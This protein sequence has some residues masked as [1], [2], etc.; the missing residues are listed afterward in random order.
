MSMRPAGLRSNSPARRPPR[1]GP[2]CGLV[3]VS[4]ATLACGAGDRGGRDA[5]GGTGGARE[6]GHGAGGDGAPGGASGQAGEPG[7]AGDSGQAGEAGQA[8][9]P[10]QGGE[11]AAGGSPGAGGA[12]T[13][14][15]LSRP[16]DS[17]SWGAPYRISVPAGLTLRPGGTPL[18]TEPRLPRA[19]PARAELSRTMALLRASTAARPSSLKVLFYG[20]SIT[21]QEWYEQVIRWFEAT[22]PTVRFQFAMLASGGQPAAKMRRASEHDVIPL[23][24]DLIIYQ[25]YGDYLDLDAIVR[26][27]R[28]RTTAEIVLQTWHLG[29][30]TGD[31][32]TSIERMSYL[33]MPNVCERYGCYLLDVRTA[34]KDHVRQNNLANAA[35]TSDGVHLNQRGIDLMAQIVIG[36]F[37]DHPASGVPVDPMRTVET[38]EV[39]AD[40]RWQ[41]D[42]LLVDFEGSRI[43]VI[44]QPGARIAA[45]AAT[46]RVDDRPPSLLDGPW[47]HTRPNESGRLIDKPEPGWPWSLGAPLRIGRNTRLQAEDWTLTITQRMGEIFQFTLRGS[48]TGDDGTGSSGARFVSRSGRVVIEPMDWHVRDPQG[49]FNIPSNQVRWRSIALH[50]DVYPPSAIE[51]PMTGAEVIT[52][53]A[54][55]LPNRR[56]RLELVSRDGRPLPIRALRVHRPVLGR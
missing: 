55:D 5:P 49:G 1:L 8:G 33:Y 15:L 51:A 3:A 43:D 53:L 28:S 54:Q 50:T 12:P 39:G 22:F 45:G 19:L 32:F 27:W 18:L 31:A 48:R 16:V 10:G 40:L 37:R 11:P 47:A 4:V 56:H 35:L 34:W 25:N 6:A 20:Q 9:A 23:Q 29:N 42:R 24:P 46:V 26:D 2:V 52:P 30:E 41:G 38:Y 13:P 17:S 36:A 7:R 14:E 44:A 21:R